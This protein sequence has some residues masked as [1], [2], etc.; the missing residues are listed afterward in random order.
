MEKIV[1][2]DRSEII[3]LVQLI[4]IFGWQRLSEKLD[5]NLPLK[6]ARDQSEKEFG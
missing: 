4:E 5:L 2:F 1:I 3:D 6:K